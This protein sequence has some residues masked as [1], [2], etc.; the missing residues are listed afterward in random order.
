MLFK[1]RFSTGNNMVGWLV[2]W[3]L[4]HINLCRLFNTK[5]I[6]MQKVKFQTNQFS[7]I[8]QFNCQ[9][10]FKLFSLFKQF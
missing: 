1:A 7:M 10:T 4:S 9:N 8:T 3:V 5:S 2:G 6:F